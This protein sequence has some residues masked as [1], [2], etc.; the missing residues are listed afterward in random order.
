MHIENNKKK[1]LSTSI[2]IIGYGMVGKAVAYGFPH[3]TH[4]IS[5]P[6]YNNNTVTDI[7]RENPIAIFV[8]VPTPT[9][10]SGLIETQILENVLNELEKALY[11]GLVIVKSTILPHFLA[12]R[13]VVYNPEFLSRAT[14]LDDFVRPPMLILG[15][16]RANEVLDLYK[17]CSNVVT[18]K[19][20]ITDIKTAAFAKYAM[21]SFY[22]TKITFMNELYHAYG[23]D[24]KALTSI[25]KEHPWMGSHHFEVP[26]PDGSFGFGGPCLVKDTEALASEYDMDLLTK[27]LEL[28]EGIRV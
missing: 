23:G 24:W 15:G 14:S 8:A 28:N 9:D 17:Q 11:L 5:D 21:N 19:V 20:F 4:Y 16:D 26:G 2:G 6:Q 7:A 25:L 13:A 10:S 18:D 22:A 27:V 3:C 1:R 12:D